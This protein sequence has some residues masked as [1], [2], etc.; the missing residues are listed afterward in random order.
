MSSTH[1]V[2]LLIGL[3]Q[4]VFCLLWSALA[5]FGLSRRAST[6]WAVTA[7][8]VTVGVMLIAQRGHLHPWLTYV[9][10]NVALLAGILLLRHGVQRFAHVGSSWRRDVL[11]LALVIAALTALRE[12]G[13]YDLIV[14]TGSTLLGLA[15]LHVGWVVARSLREELGNRLA[16]AC[17]FPV[18]AL[19]LSFMGR[20]ALL[21]QALDPAGASIHASSAASVAIGTFFFVGLLALNLNVL[22]LVIARLV[23]RLHHLSAHDGLTGL[24]NRRTIEQQ[25]T[26]QE[27]LLQRHGTPYALLSVDI[28]HFKEIND[29]HG[30]PAGDAVLRTVAGTLR[31]ALR[32][33]QIAARAGGEEFWLLLPHAGHSSA[34]ALAQHLLAEVRAQ[35]TVTHGTA[36][37]VTVSI[38]VALAD[39]AQ[40]S[41]EALMQ[42]LDAALYAAK[43][44]GRDRAV[45]APPPQ[46][47]GAPITPPEPPTP[48]ALPPPAAATPAATHFLP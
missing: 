34:M 12:V 23:Q 18:S 6:T 21:S 1:A 40:E 9:L 38:G 30:H 8:V 42:R 32:A 33:P 13:R 10:S 44:Q 43:L 35:P 4:A 37:Q 36:V 28:D 25:L 14:L 15:L 16:L 31:S 48:P 11:S 5:W 26:E 24:Y 22:A 39:D 17:A 7:L 47:R 46:Q 41:Q 19:G 29:R 45:W 27:R 3:Q 20:A 2:F